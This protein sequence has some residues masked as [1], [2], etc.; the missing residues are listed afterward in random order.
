MSELLRRVNQN[1]SCL[2]TIIK[3]I[4]RNLKGKKFEPETKALDK[5]I[6]NG[7]VCIDIGAAYG[8]Y[9]FIMSKLAGKDGKIY[10]FEPGNYSLKVLSAVVKFHRLKNVVIIKEALSDKKGFS[11]LAIPVKDKKR[12][13]PSLAHLNT[14]R[15]AG[16]F[17][18]EIEMTT[19]DEFC[20]SKAIKKIDFI[21]CDVEGAEFLVLSGA[22]TVIATFKPIVLC[23]VDQGY[24]KRFN[25]SASQI[26][27]FFAALGYQ[28]FVFSENKLLKVDN[29][30][31]DSN[32]FFVHSQSVLLPH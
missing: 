16:C 14:D 30:N 10:S 19:L 13:G 31:K 29:I 5:F 4:R 17:K 27:D 23:E 7:A 24:L 9:T 28:S 6:T 32:Y 1:L 15:D 20:S 3:T 26:L 25:S 11:Q 18:E 12:L 21:K 22:R 2:T 8:R